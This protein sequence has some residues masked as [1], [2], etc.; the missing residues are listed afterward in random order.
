[1]MAREVLVFLIVNAAITSYLAYRNL[2]R[3]SPLSHDE[4]SAYDDL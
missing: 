1:M 2:S 3:V 4:Q